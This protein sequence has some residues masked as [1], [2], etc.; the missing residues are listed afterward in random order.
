VGGKEMKV[1]IEIEL[2]IDGEYLESDKDA[3]LD[4]IYEDAG[5]R[6]WEIEEDRL[7]VFP[8]SISVELIV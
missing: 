6:A 8:K 4:R 2:E 5:A 3:L 7:I 1:V